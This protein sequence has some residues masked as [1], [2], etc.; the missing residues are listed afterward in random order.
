MP[1]S[2]SYLPSP[3]EYETRETASMHTRDTLMAVKSATKRYRANVRAEQ[4]G[5][6]LSQE[7]ANKEIHVATCTFFNDFLTRGAHAHGTQPGDVSS[8]RRLFTI[9]AG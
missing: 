4:D 5:S 2:S 8:R 7:R 3:H 1:Q 6:L 9:R